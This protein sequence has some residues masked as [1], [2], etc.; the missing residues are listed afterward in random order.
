M[1]IILV[2]VLFLTSC[3]RA[4]YTWPAL[5]RIAPNTS[6][7][8]AFIA[9]RSIE[10]LNTFMGHP[11]TKFNVDVETL[12]SYTILVRYAD[13]DEYMKAGLATMYEDVC[14]ITIFPL[15]V[16]NGIVKTVL[17]HEIAHCAGLLHVEG[18]GQIMSTSV[19]AFET[20]NSDKLEFFKNQLNEALNK[21]RK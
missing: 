19:T 10:E 15:A 20:Y 1:R 11:V 18:R 21:V 3:G 4:E 16:A 8:R 6:P 12:T 13:K 7:E 17:W 9:T 14:Y 5:I 2:L